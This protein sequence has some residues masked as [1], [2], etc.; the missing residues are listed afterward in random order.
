MSIDFMDSIISFNGTGSFLLVRS[1][2]IDLIAHDQWNS[3]VAIT[4]DTTASPSYLLAQIID[5]EFNVKPHGV[6]SLI[7]AALPSR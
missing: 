6:P 3:I 4:L 1:F 7:A 5:I 2:F